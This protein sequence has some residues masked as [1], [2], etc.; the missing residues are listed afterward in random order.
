MHILVNLKAYDVDPVAIADAMAAVPS[1]PEIELGIAPQT[2]QIGTVADRSVPVWA[3]HIAPNEPGSHTGTQ[4]AEAAASAGAVGTILNHSERQLSLA[5]I[6]A[7]LNAADRAG[8]R[9]VVCVNTPGQAAA[10]ASL[11]PDAVA[12]EP[13][14]LIGTGT[15]VSQAAPELIERAID[16]VNEIDASIPVY[17]GAGISSGADIIAAQ[18]LGADGVLVASAVAKAA[19]PAA[20][21]EEFVTSLEP[22]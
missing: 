3:Q 17:C 5:D 6:E 18:E 4:L 9:T 11:E 10:V 21:L 12:I 7:G 15:P 19:T 2:A 8:L 13:P 1:T 14:E 16:S 22:A 20:V